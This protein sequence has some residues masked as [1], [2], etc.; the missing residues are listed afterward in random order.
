MDKT[1]EI[2]VVAMVALVT[3]LVILYLANGQADGFGTFADNQQQNAQCDYYEER[4]SRTCQSNTDQIES[5]EDEAPDE[6]ILDAEPR[7]CS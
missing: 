3:G 1:I 2:I 5:F 6:C 7:S 4:I